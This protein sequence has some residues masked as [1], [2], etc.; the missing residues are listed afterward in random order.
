MTDEDFLDPVPP[1][2][3]YDDY[4]QVINQFG[5]PAVLNARQRVLFV[6]ERSRDV[7]RAVERKNTGREDAL[8]VVRCPDLH[9][10]KRPALAWAYD[11]ADG[12]MFEAALA[13]RPEDWL[14]PPAPWDVWK[15]LASIPDEVVND[16]GAVLEAT[17]RADRREPHMHYDPMPSRPNRRPHIFHDLVDLEPSPVGDQIPQLWVCCADHPLAGRVVDRAEL[18]R[19]ADAARAAGERLDFV[20]PAG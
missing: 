16:A 15:R 1:D 12:L 14:D 8:V 3:D 2:R 5:R 7:Q 4:D 11:T 9:R 17:Y 19:Q 10:A 20:W 18:R 6:H 13:W